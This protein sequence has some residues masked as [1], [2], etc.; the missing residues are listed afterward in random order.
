MVTLK[1]SASGI[2]KFWNTEGTYRGLTLR[3]IHKCCAD[4]CCENNVSES[5]LL[6]NSRSSLRSVECSVDVDVHDLLELLRGIL[7]GGMLGAN[8]G[9]G[10]N[11]V[12]SAEVLSDL[13]NRFGDFF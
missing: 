11:N 4:G 13:I 8:A 1:T 12:Q 6:E 9:V 7:F 3:C 2:S 5:L 10:Q